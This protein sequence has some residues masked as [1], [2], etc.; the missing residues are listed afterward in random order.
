M[1]IYGWYQSLLNLVDPQPNFFY[2]LLKRER[3]DNRKFL[4]SFIINL[5]AFP[6]ALLLAVILANLEEAQKRGGVIA[7]IAKKHI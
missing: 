1:N 7:V 4:I 2:N 3:I 5:V 6:F